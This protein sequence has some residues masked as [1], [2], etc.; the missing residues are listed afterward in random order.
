MFIIERTEK[1]KTL[2]FVLGRVGIEFDLMRYDIA[3]VELEN[4]KRIIKKELK[5]YNKNDG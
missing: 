3:L 5:N 4:A 2:E 1:Q